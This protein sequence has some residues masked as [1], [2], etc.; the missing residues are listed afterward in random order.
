M[1]LLTTGT[2]TTL[3]ETA[4]LQNAAMSSGITEDANDNDISADQIPA[5]FL[6]RLT[7]LGADTPSMLAL[8]GYDGT[9]GDTGA[10]VITYTPI[11]GS[12]DVYF[13]D[14][15]GGALD[16]ADSG[17]ATTSGDPI[18][19]YTDAENNNVLLGKTTG[20]DIVFSAYLEQTSNG[21]T[22]AKIWMV[23][24]EALFNPDANNPD[25]PV[26]LENLVHVTV[27]QDRS[28]SLENAPSGQ[29][30]FVMFGDSEVA[31]VVTGM[32]PANQSDGASINT[33]DTVNTSFAAGSTT[34]GIN[35][36]MV[37]P[38][39]G[40][41][42]TFV[43]GANS[44]YT[45]PH[46]SETEADIEANIAF[47][48]LYDA[49]SA[50]FSIVQ[51][52]G[53]KAATVKFTAMTTAV[54]S[55]S[56]FVDGLGDS[57]DLKVNITSVVVRDANG[58]DMT[59][60]LDVTNT[61]GVMTISGIQAG[62]SI[63]Y[64]TT[65]GHNRLLI[66][67]TGSEKGT[68]ANFDVDGFHLTDA[69]TETTE[70]GSLMRFEDDGPAI[71]LATPTDT[72]TLNTQDADTA[73]SNYDT[74]SK[75]FSGAFSIDTQSFGADGSGSAGVTWDYA[76]GVTSQGMDSEL[77]S[78]GDAIYLYLV[79][80]KVIGSTASTEGGI[81]SANT[82]FDLAVSGA[83]S[84]TL[85]QYNAVDHDAPGAS[86]DY[87]SQLET[88]GDGKVSLNGTATIADYD[89]DTDDDVKVLDLGGNI[90]FN[91]D[92]PTITLATP[93]DTVTLNTHD[94]LTIGSAF[95]TDSKSFAESFGITSSSYG[96]D[97]V[98]ASATNW[99][100]E[101]AITSQGID[102]SLA[103]NS[104]MIRLFQLASGLV[105]GS[106]AT[107]ISDVSTENTVFDLAVNSAGVVTLNQYTQINHPT[108]GADADYE[109]QTI[110]LAN[111]LVTLK[112]SATITDYDLDTAADFK[113]LDLGGNIV[114]SDHGPNAAFISDLSGPNV[115]DPIYGTYDFSIGADLVNNDEATGIVLQSLTGA[116]A[117]S[118]TTPQGRAITDASVTWEGEDDTYVNYSFAFKYY[119]GPN[120]ETTRDGSGIVIFNKSDGTY[121][122]DVDAPL[123]GESTYSTSNPLQSFNYDTL[124]N[125]S[126]EIVVQKYADDFYG[127][128][129]GQASSPPSKTITLV[130]GGDL[131]YSP[132]ETFSNSATGYVNVATDTLGVN[133]D[134]IQAGELLNYDFYSKNPVSGSTSPPQRPGAT[135][136]TNPDYRAYVDEIDI[137]LSQLN[138][139]EDIAILLKLWNPDTET[140][141]T[142]LLLADSAGDYTT[143]G[144]Y[145]VVHVG[146]E[147]YDS[148]H[149]D[150]FGLQVLSSTELLTGTGYRLSDGSAKSLGSTGTGYQDTADLDVF[151]I[152]K[153]DITSEE[154]THY[155]ADLVFSGEVIDHD[156]D[157]DGFSFQVH[158]EADGLPPFE[159]LAMEIAPTP[160]PMVM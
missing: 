93:T 32:N 13:S 86:F 11:G 94:A 27:A 25:D 111:N 114:F 58:N 31:L 53:D 6:A 158:L 88:L 119:S 79:S 116:T 38:G 70:V 50:R 1:A 48:G 107:V 126:P 84:V 24:Y 133:S 104:S 127:V 61:D 78:H 135:I 49:T 97:G 144:A 82:V 146:R 2:T 43:T 51:L 98:G 149:Y 131:A 124:G 152:I 129:T 56:N 128:L 77:T 113:I 90:S 69:V 36:Q 62:Y 66:E 137:T 20:G 145:K 148:T 23:Q 16:G 139:D 103:T 100:Y 120:S 21:E 85:T 46:L 136:D 35:N 99:A 68:A 125:K 130:S 72:I 41:Y 123:V 102:S 96:A 3:D 9:I 157:Y 91:D 47:S 30:L 75:D 12:A 153:I 57:D 110:A 54:E 83:G 134:T 44:D 33:G 52:Q 87:A 89:L 17:L 159:T 109:S 28:F 143:A 59:S 14:A 160:D 112:A 117:F 45:V 34:I 22:G 26:D 19:L 80:G 42:F 37:N 154:V 74:D 71:T 151:K 64:Q 115:A 140:A 142:R 121:M 67:N 92:G 141:T 7:A 108:P 65:A 5:E 81:D 101:L 105:V 4:E 155:D 147:D 122:F 73:G 8:S 95:D 106:T 150:I 10:N 18:L 76:L 63:E 138:S 55:G 39:E 60:S 15:F 156:A 132:G 29:N 118:S 40:L